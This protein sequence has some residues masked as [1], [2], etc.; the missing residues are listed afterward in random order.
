MGAYLYL[1][2][3]AQLVD[4]E[5]VF[6]RLRLCQHPVRRPTNEIGGEYHESFLQVNGWLGP[7][8]DA[9]KIEDLFG[10]FDTGFNGLATVVV[11]I[12]GGQVLGDRVAAKME[13]S[14]VLEF[15]A[16]MKAFERNVER[17]GA[18]RK[19]EILPSGHLGV[20]SDP[21]PDG[22]CVGLAAEIA[23]DGVVV[24]FCVDL[25]AHL[26]QQGHV[27][28]G[29]KTGIQPKLHLRRAGI[30]GIL[31]LEVRQAL[32]QMAHLSLVNDQALLGLPQ[33]LAGLIDLVSSALETV[34]TS[35][36]AF[37]GQGQLAGWS[38]QSSARLIHLLQFSQ[39]GLSLKQ[40]CLGF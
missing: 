12:P 20:G 14:A 11:G 35:P 5:C 24:R 7:H 19:L 29:T 21:C 22:F 39:Q 16:S 15:L 6:H 13:Q 4:G 25:V 18:V 37:A 23:D 27:F 26:D 28:V 31:L 3:D 2:L 17:I 1:A 38:F 33:T 40:F 8:L 34:L 32:P 9:M 30:G 10:F 36:Q